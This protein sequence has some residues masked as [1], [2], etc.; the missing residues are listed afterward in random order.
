MNNIET[1]RELMKLDARVNES[2]VEK[3]FEKIAM[4]L[5]W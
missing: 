5:F 1:L 2:G 4:L 3:R